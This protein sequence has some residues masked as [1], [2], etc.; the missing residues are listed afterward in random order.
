MSYFNFF[1]F[2][3]VADQSHVCTSYQ[4]S[5]S[6]VRIRMFTFAVV[7]SCTGLSSFKMVL[8]GSMVSVAQCTVYA[9]WICVIIFCDR[10][11]LIFILNGEEIR[12]IFTF[13]MKKWCAGHFVCTVFT[14]VVGDKVMYVVVLLS[15]CLIAYLFFYLYSSLIFWPVFCHLLSLSKRGF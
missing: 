9:W 7:K 11:R 14:T 13:F 5:Y 2:C 15:H 8:A 3:L 4:Q 1:G 10:S 12:Q 6:S